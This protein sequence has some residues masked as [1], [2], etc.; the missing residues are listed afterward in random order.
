[1]VFILLL[2]RDRLQ[3]AFPDGG[4]D[5]RRGEES[6][7]RSCRLRMFAARRDAGGKHGDFLDLGRQRSDV[8]DARHGQQL[9]D[10]LK[11]DLGVAARDRGADGRADDPRALAH[12]LIGDAESLKEL[13]GHVDAAGAGGIRD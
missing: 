3:A 11:A 1:M 7:Q 10:L 8:V 2:G 6:D 9:A 4:D 5:G 12:H 13:G